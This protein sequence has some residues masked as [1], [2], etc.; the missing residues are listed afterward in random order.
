MYVSSYYF[1]VTVMY[2]Y[3]RTGQTG[4][5]GRGTRA[6]SSPTTLSSWSRGFALAAADATASS[7]TLGMLRE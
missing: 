3:V 4:G 2:S 1:I 5:S 7:E 6:P